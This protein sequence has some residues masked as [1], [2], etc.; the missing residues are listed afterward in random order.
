MKLRDCVVSGLTVV[1]IFTGA[2]IGVAISQPAPMPP[3]APAKVRWMAFAS[4][5]NERAVIIDLKT[6][7]LQTSP[8]ASTN[9][10]VNTTPEMQAVRILEQKLWECQHP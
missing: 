1:C 5:F 2:F 9:S 10:I 8:A 4:Q 3:E 6:G 7:D